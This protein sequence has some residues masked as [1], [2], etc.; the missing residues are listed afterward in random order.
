MKRFTWLVLAVVAMWL[1]AG[2][3]DG[4]PTA[5]FAESD[6]MLDDLSDDEL[7]KL[8]LDLLPVLEEN[9]SIDV[10]VQAD[11][12][13]LFHQV[14]SPAVERTMLFDPAVI[15]KARQNGAVIWK[16]TPEQAVIWKMTTDQAVIWKFV[17]EL[18][19]RGLPVDDNF[20]LIHTVK[21]HVDLRAVVELAQMDEVAYITPD[22]Q[23]KVSAINMW[24]QTT[25]VFMANERQT[26]INFSG[27]TGAGVGIAVLDSGI[28]K[29]HGDFA[30]SSG[31]RVI[32]KR[33]FT[34][35]G[36]IANVT[37]GYGHGTHV[38]ALAAGNGKRSFDDTYDAY[39]EGVAPEARLIVAKVLDSNGSGYISNVIS[40]LDWVI[41]KKNV[42]NIRVV[43]LSLGLPP[44][45][46]WQQ[47]PL[48]QAVENAVANGLVVVVAA[49]NYGFYQ[50]QVL[51][52]SI[53]SPGISPSAITVGASITHDTAL[54][55]QDANDNNDDVALFSSRGPTAWDGLA[56]PDLIAPGKDIISAYSSGCTLGQL[57]PQQIIDACDVGGSIC[58]DQNAYYLK[59]S[60]TSM[61]SPTVAG[62]AALMLEA[63]PNLTP[64]ALKA[65]LMLTSQPLLDEVSQSYCYNYPGWREDEFCIPQHEIEQ[66]SGLVNI[67]GATNMILSTDISPDLQPGDPW[68]NDP[69]LTPETTFSNTGELVIWGQGLAWTGGIVTGV[70]MW[71]VYQEPYQPGVIWGTG[72]AWTGGI[73]IGEDPVFNTEIMN[74]WTG[75]FINPFSLAGENEVLGGFNYDWTEEPDLSGANDVWFPQD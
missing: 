16:L 45:D 10:L 50:G 48:C 21:M 27:L 61:A 24:N 2:C 59:L 63:N 7:A 64:N 33:N 47:D 31:N 66:G 18:T 12:Q 44:V 37:D 25:G 22:R 28:K 9:G 38:A 19:Q 43:N 8:S 58:G 72:L 3:G 71:K 1:I 36:T 60:G 32:A 56:K 39:Y 20:D 35:I 46:P 69:N 29:Y 57:Y 13:V 30:G 26:A 17:D 54:R 75:S 62:T 67:A 34:G 51:Y 52:G 68:V 4:E 65:V 5:T 73:T 49:G 53:A 6:Q 14:I 55:Q 15:W 23:V 42:F 40:A 70:D 41:S 74:I 11:P